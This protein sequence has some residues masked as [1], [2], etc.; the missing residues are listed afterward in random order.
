MTSTTPPGSSARGR[1]RRGRPKPAAPAAQPAASKS[2]INKHCSRFS[3]FSRLINDSNFCSGNRFRTS[4]PEAVEPLRPARMA[5]RG[6]RHG[7]W[8]VPSCS[9]PYSRWL[10]RPLL[11]AAPHHHD[12]VAPAHDDAAARSQRCRALSLPY[13]TTLTCSPLPISRGACDS[14]RHLDAPTAYRTIFNHFNP[15][16]SVI[17]RLHGPMVQPRWS[18]L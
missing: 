10:L 13:E 6:H 15:P 4:S 5:T 14:D 8:P 12:I 2:L 16:S 3:R 18:Y 1:G 9:A 17:R 7:R 11:P